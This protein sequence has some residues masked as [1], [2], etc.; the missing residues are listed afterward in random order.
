M[1]EPTHKPS[2]CK[3]GMVLFGDI[4][5]VRHLIAPYTEGRFG[6]N[7]KYYGLG[8]GKVDP[9]ED[10]LDAAMRECSE[11]TGIDVRKLLGEDN[12]AKI[13]RGEPVENADSGY[14]GVRVKRVIPNA[15]EYEYLGREGKPHEFAL[16][17][18]ELE[19]IEHLYDYLKNKDNRS[20][21][22]GLPQEVYHPIRTMLATHPDAYPSMQQCLDWL[23]TMRMP[24]VP[25]A[26][27]RGGEPLQPLNGEPAH[28]FTDLEQEFMQKLG[29][30]GEHI[31][32]VREWQSFQKG[33]SRE[34]YR[35]IHGHAEQIKQV[36]TELQI[37]SGNDHDIL[38][39]DTK[40]SPLVFYQEGADI[41]TAENY[42]KTTIKSGIRR[43]DFN[44]AFCGNLP[45][46]QDVP[47]MTRITS[48]QLAGVVWAAGD[49]AIE[50]VADGFL[51]KPVKT[52]GDNAWLGGNMY[53]DSIR[54]DLRGAMDVMKQQ[55]VPIDKI[56]QASNEGTLGTH[57]QRSA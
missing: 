30:P 42:L 45:N 37:L 22:I 24:D 5:G 52:V 33:L 26:G 12:I 50:Q 39:F 55:T 56:L 18:F 4:N 48:S 43:G 29:R 57:R 25:W 53:D 28:W 7:Y 44:L 2:S 36:L 13:R 34:Q 54:H 38:K 14:P 35:L 49:Q 1:T 9:G 3:A 31:R 23:R 41:L 27:G 6:N 15:L 40:D 8:K 51:K 21:Y 16:F 11:E 47:R 19:G 10:L 17:A 32:N 46:L 20:H